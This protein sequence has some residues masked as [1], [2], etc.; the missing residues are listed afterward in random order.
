MRKSRVAAKQPIGDG[1]IELVEM[2]SKE[3]V[4]VIDDDQL[5][6]AGQRGNEFSNLSYRTM[7]VI[8]AMDKEFGLRAAP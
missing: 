1:L 5:V 2:A 6:F 4:G 8:G 3:M 7:L